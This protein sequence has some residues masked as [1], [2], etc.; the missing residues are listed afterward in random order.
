MLILIDD[1]TVVQKDATGKK[2][3]LKVPLAA[4]E[5]GHRARR[6]RVWPLAPPSRDVGTS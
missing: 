2:T 1:T 5:V 6:V 4:H 3:Y